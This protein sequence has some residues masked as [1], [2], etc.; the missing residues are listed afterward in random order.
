[1]IDFNKLNTTYL[2]ESELLSISS[3]EWS[4]IH[5]IDTNE[6]RYPITGKYHCMTLKINPNSKILSGSIHKLRNIIEKSENQNY[7]DFNFSDIKRM[8]HHLKDVFSLNLEN[9]I[10]QNLEIGINISTTKP[11]ESILDENLIAW[12]Y[13]TP[14]ENKKYNGKGRYIEFETSSSYL[15]IYDKGLQ[16]VLSENILRVELKIMRNEFLVKHGIQYLSD[17]LE[18][19]NLKKLGGLLIEIANKAIIVDDMPLK[20]IE[21]T[22]EAE[23]INYG[24]NP[25]YWTKL[26]RMQRSRFK[27]K[28][29][30]ILEKYSLNTLKKEITAK[31]QSK[32]D[33]LLQCYEM[34]D[35]VGA[36]N[37]SVMLRNETLIYFHSVTKRKCIVTG[38][39]IS[40]QKD[41][42][43]FLSESSIF[44]MYQDKH[45]D[46]E[47]LRKK[48]GGRMKNESNIKKLCYY[49]AHNIRNRDSNKRREILRKKETYQN[50]LFPMNE[51]FD[52]YYNKYIMTNI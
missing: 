35:F 6:L 18:I 4:E 15:K 9:T 42:S 27:D 24:L 48:F 43:L 34:N 16:N 49:I 39:D 32:I 1:M 21:C 41:D 26:T 30:S 47:K 46:F 31:M 33:E 45:Q 40:H 12:N 8:I 5:V 7:D 29:E 20:N 2:K 52:I 36:W 37:Y 22:N 14:S 13:K 19:D 10:I 23:I 25:L 28:F 17:L 3:I 51:S 50:T 11:P 44:A 38:I